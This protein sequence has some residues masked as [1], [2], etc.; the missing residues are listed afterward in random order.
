LLLACRWLVTPTVIGQDGSKPNAFALKTISKRVVLKS[1]LVAAVL[2]EKNVLESIQHP[3]L[4]SLVQ[5]FQ[6]K[7]NLYLMLD[8]VLGGE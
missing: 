6:D 3:F 1:N 5:S 4:L 2:R 8:L 7:D